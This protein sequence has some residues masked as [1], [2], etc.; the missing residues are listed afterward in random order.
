MRCD[1]IV[2]WLGAQATLLAGRFSEW[3][4]VCPPLSQHVP[5]LSQSKEGG[6]PKAGT[7]SKR[8]SLIALIDAGDT[9]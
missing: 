9:N 7:H 5:T 2:P 4:G 6:I 8:V 1:L 3:A